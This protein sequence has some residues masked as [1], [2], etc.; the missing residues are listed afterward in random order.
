M[1]KSTRT[2][3][4]SMLVILV[5]LVAVIV[6]LVLT[7]KQVVSEDKLGETVLAEQAAQESTA[8]EEEQIQEE[9]TTEPSS[10]DLPNEKE[11]RLYVG[12]GGVMELITSY[13]ST[14]SPDYDIAIFEA[15]NS[16]EDTIYYDNY[17]TLHEM[18][19]NA[20]ESDTEYKIGYELSFEV[21][22]E[23]K[24]YT[25]LKPADISDNADLFMGNV[26]T[27]EIT[28]YMGVWVYNDI[29]QERI[30]VHLTQEDMADGVLMTSI[31]LRP[32]PQSSEISNFKLKV[33]S[34]SSDTE[35]NSQGRYIG[36]HGYEISVNNQ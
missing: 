30:Y 36:T 1:K 13:D 26:E 6:V 29:G 17:Y 11:L 35:F 8:A 14:W 20:V 10:V 25:I 9:T 28:G 27:D 24:V 18:Y 23:Q 31:K 2:A 32:T 16:T 33:F 34:Y 19:W 21:N 22:G 3:L 15:I 7:D 12:G 5:I 4:V